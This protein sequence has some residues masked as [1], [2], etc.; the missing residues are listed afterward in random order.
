M[1]LTQPLE[2]LG[3]VLLRFRLL[4][5]LWAAL[6][7]MVNGSSVLFL[8]TFYGQAALAAM[9]AAIVT[10][11]VIYARLGFVRLL[12]IGHVFWIPMLIWFAWHPPD[13]MQ[14]PLL[15]SWVLSLMIC[16]TL[17]LLIDAIDVVRFIAGERH[18]HYTWKEST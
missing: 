13:K 17:S 15:Y 5:R 16:N 12:G 14:Q 6:L 11:A 9:C 10:M 2:I 1:K 8:H 4:P 3:I 18:P 7:I